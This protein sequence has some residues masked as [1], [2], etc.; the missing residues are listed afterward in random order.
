VTRPPPRRRIVWRRTYRLIPARYPPVA[1]FERVADPVDWETLLAVESLTNEHIR[2]E[3]GDVRLVPREDRVS[4][5]GA[6][7]V[8]A[9][10]THVG[11][12]S[13]FSDG[14]YGVYYTART[15]DCAIAETVYHVGRFLAATTEPPCD[16]DMR[17]L[18]AGIDAV[19]HDIRR[20]RMRE[21]YDPEDYA[22]AQT[23]GHMLR[24]G[25]SSGI[26]Y[27]SVR[28]AESECVAAFRPRVVRT[29]PSGNGYLLYHWD[30]ARID[31]YYDYSADR[32]CGTG[33]E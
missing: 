29:L 18:V 3:V 25:G 13:R 11:W 8:M 17:I 30:G 14:S 7:W 15:R 28:L 6:S 33:G 23:F 21:V 16:V 9:A 26:V 10:F 2:D 12:P 20:A 27:R 22:A 5:P 19:L 4:G 31:R 24:A 32:W 1:L